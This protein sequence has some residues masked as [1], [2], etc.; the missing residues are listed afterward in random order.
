MSQ[1]KTQNIFASQ[2]THLMHDGGATPR[3]DPRADSRVHRGKPSGQGFLGTSVLP[4]M[5]KKV[6]S[7]DN[8]S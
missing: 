7:P 2:G 6:P 5:T 4:S 3:D 1:A 8:S